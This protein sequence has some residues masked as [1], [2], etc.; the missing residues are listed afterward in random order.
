[1]MTKLLFS[2]LVFLLLISGCK[3][4]TV[5]KIPTSTNP[6]TIIYQEF[7]TMTNSF[8]T[9]T[10]INLYYDSIGV[11]FDSI[12]GQTGNTTTV[13]HSLYAT[14]RYLILNLYP[15]LDST[16]TNLIKFDNTGRIVELHD[17]YNLLTDKTASEGDWSN[18]EIAYNNFSGSSPVL[19]HFATM[20]VF[21][22]I[23][24]FSYNFDVTDYYNDSMKIGTG[25][26]HDAFYDRYL[27][28]TVNF[29]TST[30]NSNLLSLSGYLINGS[31]GNINST[32]SYLFANIN[33]L[34]I[35]KLNMKLA[36]SIYAT[37][38]SG[39]PVYIKLADFS[40]EF[41]TENRVTKATI[42]YY[43][44]NQ[45]FVSNILTKR[46]LINY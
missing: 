8:I 1:M 45:F 46:I 34:P 39:D 24:D 19:S 10:S 23:S 17:Y 21:S 4:E 35:P 36:K 33:L 11:Y 16:N 26:N 12:S 22:S 31:I 29:D 41:D 6:A 38:Y 14:K 18:N 40:Y 44:S 37:E 25:R 27:K 42:N 20:D 9:V 30:N 15:V 43:N 32:A 2:I 13:N 5:N 7:D 28:Y 3:R